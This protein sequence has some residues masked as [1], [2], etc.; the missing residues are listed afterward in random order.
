MIGTITGESLVHFNRPKGGPAMKAVN[1]SKRSQNSVSRRD[2]LK[3]SAASAASAA[4]LASGN[5]AFAA[6]SDVIKVGIIGCGGRGSGA[7]V[8]ALESSPGVELMAMADLFPDHL[9][10]KKKGFSSQF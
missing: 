8:N 4:M 7:V 1:N 9:E 3:T 5:Y 10:G 2:F 6:G